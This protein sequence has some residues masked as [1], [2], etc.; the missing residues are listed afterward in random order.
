MAPNA[1]FVTP[2][3]SKSRCTGSADMTAP[4][5][6]VILYYSCFVIFRGVGWIL[7]VREAGVEVTL[8]YM[9]GLY[10]LICPSHYLGIAIALTFFSAGSY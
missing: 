1:Y 8:R 9:E 7:E 6:R 3:L 4:C 5:S 10:F 2:T